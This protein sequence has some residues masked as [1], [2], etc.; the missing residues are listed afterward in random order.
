MGVIALY[1]VNNWALLQRGRWQPQTVPA[2]RQHLA[3]LFMFFA[4]LWAVGNL[5]NMADLVYS[6]GGVV[7]GASYTDVHATLPALRWQTGLMVFLA[8]ALGYNIIRFDWRPVVLAGG[9]WLMVALIGGNI[10]PALMQRYAVEP[11]ELDRETPYIDYNIRF[12][13]LAF[14]LDSITP[15]PFTPGSGVTRQDV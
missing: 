12:T 10:Y 7:F 15:I 5:I 6:P 3:L 13:R 8:L 14:D 2:V 11:N 9:L 1:S 4:V